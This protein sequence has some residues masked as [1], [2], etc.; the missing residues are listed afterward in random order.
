MYYEG[1]EGIMHN[2]EIIYCALTK[3]CVVLGENLVEAR[4][5]EGDIPE[6]DIMQGGIERHGPIPSY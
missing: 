6:G 5:P 4:F 1:V 3:L 2:F